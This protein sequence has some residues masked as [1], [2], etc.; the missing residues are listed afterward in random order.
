[1]FGHDPREY[2]KT[3]KEFISD[4]KGM[5]KALRVVTVRWDR[6]ESARMK[7]IE[8]SGSEKILEADLVLLAM[9]FMGADKELP[10]TLGLELDERTNIKTKKG[11]CKTAIEG[12]FAAGD[13]RTGQSLVVWA[14]NEGRK[15]AL[16]CNREL[17]CK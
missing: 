3:V 2:C 12:I 1:M 14:I 8:V 16:E 17:R 9:G 15:A 4:D 13:A 6:D 5:V 7:M 11:S 10:N